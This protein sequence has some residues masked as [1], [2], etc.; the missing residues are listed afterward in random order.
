MENK[1]SILYAEDDALGAE[2]I[3]A[4]LERNHFLVDIA[5]DG[6]KAWE[7]YKRKKPDIL[8]LDL[9]MPQK[10]GLEVTRLIREQDKQTHIIVYTSHG[11]AEREIAILDA[12]ADEFIC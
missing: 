8:L 1:N 12:G 9:D 10:N 6:E 2:L 11:E 3:K 5:S 7:S 4:I